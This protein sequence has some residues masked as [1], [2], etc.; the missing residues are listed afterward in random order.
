M[1]PYCLRIMGAESKDLMLKRLGGGRSSRQAGRCSGTLF[2]SRES[3]AEQVPHPA[4]PS[5]RAPQGSGW[6]LVEFTERA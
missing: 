4:R 1:N 2:G 5:P 3:A 6:G